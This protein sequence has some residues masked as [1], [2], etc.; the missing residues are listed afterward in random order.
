MTSFRLYHANGCDGHDHD[1]D[2][3][4]HVH[5]LSEVRTFHMLL[6]RS[7]QTWELLHYMAVMADMMLSYHGCGCAHGH[8]NESGS[9]HDCVHFR[10]H[11]HAHAHG[12]F[13]NDR[14][15]GYADLRWIDSMV[16]TCLQSTVRIGLNA[17]VKMNGNG[18]VHVHVHVRGDYW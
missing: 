12:E 2:E 14:V 5:R 11:V 9:G 1:G 13:R 16:S 18:N 10:V 3:R 6:S 8:A 4:Q 7:W 17:N 15:N